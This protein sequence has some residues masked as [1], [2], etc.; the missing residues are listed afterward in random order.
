MEN[1]IRDLNMSYR[2]LYDAKNL[3]KKKHE[4]HKVTHLRIIGQ[5]GLTVELK[6]HNQNLHPWAD[7]PKA[8]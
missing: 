3:T 6:I 2:N 1:P 4:T 7:I 5:V 8:T